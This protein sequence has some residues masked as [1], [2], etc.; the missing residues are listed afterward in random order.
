MKHHRHCR[1]RRRIGLA[2]GHLRHHIHAIGH[3]RE[4]LVDESGI[5]HRPH[6]FVRNR[7]LFGSPIR[8]SPN[9]RLPQIIHRRPRQIAQNIHIV[10][11]NLPQWKRLRRVRLR[12]QHQPLRQRGVVCRIA[13]NQVVVVPGNIQLRKHRRRVR[14]R[15]RPRKRQRQ[16]PRRIQRPHLLRQLL[17]NPRPAIHLQLR[18]LVPNPPDH[19]RRMVPVAQHHRRDIALPPRV[20]IIPIVELHLVRLPRIERLIQHQQPEPVARIQKCRRRRIVR[21]PHRVV[22]RPLQQLHPPLLGPVKRRRPQRP[23][24]VVHAPTRQL[25]RL[26]IQ[27]QPRLRRPRQRP[28]PERRLHLVH[29]LA[30]LANPRNRAVHRR[31]LRRP[32]R[33]PGHGDRLL[34]HHPLS[35]RHRQRRLRLSRLMPR[36]VVQRRL[37]R[38]PGLICRFVLHLR[39]NRDRRRVLRLPGRRNK[40][41]PVRHMRR[42]RHHHPHMPV[43]PRSAVPPAVRQRRVIHPHRQHIRSRKIQAPRQIERKARISIRMHPQLVAVQVHRRVPV[44]PVELHAHPLAPPLG[45]RVERLPVPAHAAGKEPTPR[46]RQVLRIRSAFNAPVVRQLHRAPRR[47]RKPGRFGPTGVA[48]HKP[49]IRVGLERQPRRIRL[50]PQGKGSQPRQSGAECNNSTQMQFHTDLIS[51]TL[52]RALGCG[53]TISGK[54]HHCGRRGF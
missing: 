39:L 27:Q 28:Y 51:V 48:Q 9:S 23:V 17:A 15:R 40:H 18:Y 20:K 42:G 2:L 49:P 4:Q 52:V 41:T 47:V 32:Q 45:R 31:P 50:R 25:H 26:S 46:A 44:H 30:A 13:R 21:R 43:D 3:P 16:R 33:R 22:P 6:H 7:R 35:R 38:H 24:I 36:A 34:C 54:N 29:H 5:H 53:F 37:H 10:L 1:R 11:R 14:C 8:P 19:N 12:R